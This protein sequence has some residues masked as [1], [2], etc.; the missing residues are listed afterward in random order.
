MGGRESSEK[1][2]GYW[3]GSR[4]KKKEEILKKKIARI[5]TELSIIW[6][7]DGYVNKT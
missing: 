7:I 2:D 4:V 6:D 5:V 1:N 3:L